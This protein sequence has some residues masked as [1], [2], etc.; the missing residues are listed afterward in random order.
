M[1][2]EASQSPQRCGFCV[3]YV[4]ACPSETLAIRR[5]VAVTMTVTGSVREPCTASMPLTDTAIR[6][7]KPDGKQKKLSDTG[8]LYLLLRPDGARY[9]RLDYRRPVTKSR[10][11][12][13]LGVYPDVGL[14]EARTRRDEARKLLASGAD[15][16]LR[17]KAEK[18]A[19]I[20]RAANS[21]EFVA[22]EWLA[23]REHE[24]TPRQ[25]EKERARLEKHVFPWVGEKPIADL[26]V[27][28]VRPLIERLAK[29]GHLEQAHRL[30]FQLSRIF[31]FAVATERA[32]RDP[33][34]DLRAVLP[35]RNKKN[36]ATITDPGRV[37]E[38]LNAIEGFKGT[39]PVAC[40]LRLA[41]LWFCRPGEIRMAEWSHFQL[42]G[43]QPI[44]SIP[45]SNRKLR[46]AD[47]ENPQTPPHIVPL[48][49]QSISILKEL[50]P[51]T[52][53]GRY[54]FPSARD[55]KRHMSDGAIN[56]ALARIGFKGELVGHGFRHMASTML[57][58][59][60]WPADV[61]ERQLA[62]KEPGI[63][64]IYN[65]A[66]HMPERKRMMQAWADHLDELK[67]L[68]RLQTPNDDRKA[69]QS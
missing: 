18:S 68:N 64:G 35:R 9:W 60:G 56:A 10:N 23:I 69:D 20:E 11:T 32:E 1:S 25:H 47:K 22:R 66:E 2:S 63:A 44:Y 4:P 30:R 67:S 58:E 27:G 37:S 21:F 43:D 3:F 7:A 54:L 5:L 19:G 34:A 45:P 40:A 51:L 8:G 65:K 15:P 36:F 48:S 52:G 38:L 6:K 24:W 59:A 61:V 29:L 17:R 33:A 50:R 42:D 13:S 28:E 46:K 55:A 49:R 12:L 57:R 41:P 62:H 16:G 53:Q 31:Q 14:A 26:G 39:F